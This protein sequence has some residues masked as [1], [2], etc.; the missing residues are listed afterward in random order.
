MTILHFLYYYTHVLRLSYS[1]FFKNARLKF[2]FY[3]VKFINHFVKNCPHSIA[4]SD[5]W[6]WYRFYDLIKDKKHR[7]L[8]DC[9]YKMKKHRRNTLRI[10]N[11]N[12]NKRPPA[13][14]NSRLSRDYNYTSYNFTTYILVMS[15]YMC[16][17]LWHFNRG[18]SRTKKSHFHNLYNC[19]IHCICRY[20]YHHIML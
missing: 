4:S 3:W 19:Y 10:H 17:I 1:Y 8:H 6:I 13:S 5:P 11:I 14:E 12:I 18:S 15:F 20:K 9:I 16:L 2:D 7:L